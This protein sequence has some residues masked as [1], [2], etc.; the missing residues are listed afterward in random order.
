M[1]PLVRHFCEVGFGSPDVVTLVYVVKI[2]AL[3]ARRLAAH[4]ARRPGSTGSRAFPDWWRDPIVFYKAVALDDALRGARPRLRLRPAQPA[5]HAAAGLVPLLAAAG[6][7]PAPAVAGPGAAH[8]RRLAAPSST[9][10]CTPP[11]VVALVVRGARRAAALAGLRSPSAL[12]ARVGLRDKTIFLAARSEVY[13]HPGRHLPVRRA[14][15]RWWRAKL[16]MVAIW[17]GAATSKLNRHFPYVVAA[18][19][20]NSP[21]WRCE[22]DQ[23]PVPPRLPRRP[24][25]VT[26]L[27]VRAHAGTVVEFGVPLLL[28]L[29]DGGTGHQGRRGGDD[30][31]P[32]QHHQQRA[33]GRPAGVE[34]LHDPRDPDPLRRPRRRPTS[35]TWCTRC[36]SSS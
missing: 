6:H 25:P 33:D 32:P 20:S 17:W 27:G 4:P 24:A 28:L 16:V 12:L 3:R 2:V 7:D 23:A 1:R 10:C 34:R 15:T 26:H 9:S 18:M 19:M 8:P 5:V 36:P 13:A 11:C 14:A 21:V 30:L 29:G 22:D 31:L 35:T